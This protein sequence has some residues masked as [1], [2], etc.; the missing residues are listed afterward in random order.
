[1][2]TF[3]AAVLF[4]ALFGA[5]VAHASPPADPD[6]NLHSLR[7]D[8]LMVALPTEKSLALLPDLRNPAKIEAA[9]ATLLD[10]IAKKQATLLDWPQAITTS[11]FEAI[12]ENTVGETYPEEGDHS[13]SFPSPF[14]SHY[15]I[16]GHTIFPSTFDTRPVGSR[17]RIEPFVS[18]DGTRAT[19]DLQASFVRLLRYKPIS[20]G[21]SVKAGPLAV[22]QPIFQALKTDT[23][24][25]LRDGE[26]RLLYVGSSFEPGSPT[27]LFIVGL[28]IFPSVQPAPSHP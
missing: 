7:V 11:G 15:Y 24:L 17:L 3:F 10:F 2:K 25:S 18:A 22:G 1:M 16:F 19:M 20:A 9:Q 26:R 4:L 13:G 27:V 8:V 21:T 14:P 5:T 6:P 12:T 28:K 23:T